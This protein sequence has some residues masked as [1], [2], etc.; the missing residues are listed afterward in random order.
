MIAGSHTVSN[1]ERKCGLPPPTTRE[2]PR[3]TENCSNFLGE[4]LCK[5]NVIASLEFVLSTVFCDLFLFLF[6]TMM[7]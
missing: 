4:M 1:V 5:F 6:F 7:R 3:K 2:M